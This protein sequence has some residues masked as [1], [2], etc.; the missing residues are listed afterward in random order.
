MV[1]IADML[2]VS[3]MAVAI[4]LS[5][6]ASEL[7]EKITAYL[8]V[9]RNGKLAEISVC[10]FMGSKVNHNSFLLAILP[11]VAAAK[12]HGPVTGIISIPFTVMTVLTLVA[13]ISLARRK[14]EPWQGW[15][16]VV[17]Y[18]TTIGAAYMVR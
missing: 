14:L 18:L 13:G 17:L 6:I 11:F 9:M 2:G 4:V 10:N 3:A 8:T 1:H 16:F 12:G 15:L 5:P 7:P